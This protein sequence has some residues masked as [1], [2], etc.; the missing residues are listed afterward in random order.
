MIVAQSRS[1]ECS[2]QWFVDFAFGEYSAMVCDGPLSRFRTF[3]T[4]G[5]ALEWL[6]V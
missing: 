1:V 5:E 3:K 4:I 2:R 6:L